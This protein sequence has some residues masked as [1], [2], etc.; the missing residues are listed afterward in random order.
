MAIVQEPSF[1]AFPIALS[2]DHELVIVIVSPGLAHPQMRAE[3]FCCK[4]MLSL[5]RDDR[6]RVALAVIVNRIAN[7]DRIDFFMIT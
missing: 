5:I 4:T 7:S 3:A 1:D 2:D 6:R